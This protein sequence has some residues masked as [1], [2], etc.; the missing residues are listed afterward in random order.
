MD[1]Q[2][3]K[4]STEES[5]SAPN[6]NPGKLALLHTG[7]VLAL[8]LIV[9]LLNYLLGLGM[10][11]AGGLSGVAV[12]SVFASAQTILSM[13]STLALPFWQV[14]IICI[15]L[16]FALKEQAS[17]KDLLGG[18]YRFGGVLRLTL[19]FILIFVGVMLASSYIATTLFMFSPA[20]DGF[21]TAVEKL[22][23]NPDV[24]AI[25]TEQL[26]EIAP[27]LNWVML[28]N[29][30]VM[31]VLGLPL[32]YRFRLS[33]FALMNGAPG[34]LAAMKESTRLTR[35][36]RMLLFKFDLSIWWYYGLQL[37]I[38][39]IG[40]GDM[41]LGLLGITLP[42]DSTLLF[43]ILLVLSGA[44]NLAF[45]WKYGVWYQTAYAHCYLKL[46]EWE[47]TTPEEQPPKMPYEKY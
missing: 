20:A 34:A 16:R 3:I 27:Q 38:A 18:F 36:R 2:M 5:L 29:F 14:G 25:S 28:L 33:E 11:S 43:V 1:P 40:S 26:L 17:P 21:Y 30:A 23:E 24:T 4:K 47:E 39:L 32:Y 31:L 8:N 15:G 7:A 45:A 19:F 22:M 9:M 35:Y 46:K 42:V 44:A 41:V 37:L 10:N 6:Y 12:R 13:A